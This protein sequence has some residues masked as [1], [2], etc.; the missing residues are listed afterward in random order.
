MI[1]DYSRKKPIKEFD[2]NQTMYSLVS[3]ESK[4]YENLEAT[5]FLGNSI[6]YENLLLS[7]DKL[8]K[9]FK[10]SGISEGDAVAILT[11]SMPTV[12]Q[13]LLSL[14]K[15]GA[16]M[17]WIDLRAK[18]K[19]LI[20][21]I[22]TSKCKTVVVFEDML[23]MIEKII[24]ETDIEKV[25]VASPKDY[26]NP[27]IR[28]L[29]KL[30][31]KMEGK[32]IAIPN[33]SRFV[34]INDFINSA[35]NYKDLE[36]ISFDKER[37]SLIVQSSGSTGKPKQIVHTEYNFNSEVQKIAYTDL[38]FYRGTTM[39]ISIPPFIIYGLGNSIYSSL[40]FTM[41][42][43]MNPF[44]D[45]NTV[46]NDLGKFDMSLAAPVHYRY[47]YNKLIELYDSIDE[48]EKDKSLSSKKELSK[49]LKELKRVMNGINRA[50]VFVSGGDKISSEELLKMEQLFDTQIINGYGNNE[51]LGA[52]IVSPVYGNKPGSI[53][54]P[55][56][57]VAIKV[58]DPETE[59]EVAP[60]S[61][62]ELYI[63]SDN[64]FKYYLNNEEE[65][66]RIKYIDENG[67]EWIRTGDL[68]F[69][70]EDGYIIHKGRNKRL[71]KKEAF[72]ISPDA[73]EEVISKLPF[74][75]GCIVVGVDDVQSLSVP[76]AFIVL[77]DNL[78]DWNEA[79]ESIIKECKENLPD[80]E[81]PTYFEKIEKIPYT[82]NEKQDFKKLE[83]IGNEIVRSKKLVRK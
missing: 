57:G 52:S 64:I 34:R 66:K 33:D 77:N 74:V 38:P 76:M 13:C 41:K 50:K 16:Q 80:Y 36:P 59:M 62:G 63:S 46:Y 69:V 51:C 19:D 61:V 48:L 67:K 25:I 28:T 35:I 47:I 70:D 26:L 10:D 7:A 53:G 2:I 5:G 55:L 15:I 79:K 81:V 18:D 29:A 4:G 65:T 31:D 30:K 43:E 60:H 24:S 58:V 45:E 56:K 72:K 27:L 12:Q 44:V 71:I 75:D 82:Q 73:I 3:N 37:P 22:N 20:N 1:N 49:K 68:C 9:S 40:V 83:R 54:V 39:H 23:P 17:V 21:Y 8:A 14:S 11:I 42:A 78:L 32:K 6:T